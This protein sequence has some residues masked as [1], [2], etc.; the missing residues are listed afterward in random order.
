LKPAT[1]RS[2]DS[3]DDRENAD[4]VLGRALA[5]TRCLQPKGRDQYIPQPQER[6]SPSWLA[7]EH[8]LRGATRIHR[9][10][11]DRYTIGI[12]ELRARKQGG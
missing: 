9:R 4:H 3:L 12:G 10:I 1:S 8:P 5:R 2:G 11:V 6:M 7:P